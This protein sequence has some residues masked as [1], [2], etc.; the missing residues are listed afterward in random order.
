MRM[1]KVT[2]TLLDGSKKEM[3]YDADAPCLSCGLPVEEASMGGTRICPACD[4][5]QHRNGRKW[6]L[7]EAEIFGK[8][9]R[10]N[11]AAK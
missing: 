1:K 3:D 4:C 9:Y 8:K 7:K 11:I 10:D 5:G 6:T 2:Y